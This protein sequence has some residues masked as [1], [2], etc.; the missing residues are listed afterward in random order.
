MKKCIPVCRNIKEGT[1]DVIVS[2]TLS[3][4]TETAA[5]ELTA[6][7]PVTDTSQ[8]VKDKE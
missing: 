1:F 3:A 6:E 7:T 4:R 5:P 8:I 2:N